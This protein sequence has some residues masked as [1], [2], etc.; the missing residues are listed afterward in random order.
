MNRAYSLEDSSSSI[1]PESV[2]RLLQ[3]NENQIKT[4]MDHFSF[5]LHCLML[6]TGFSDANDDKNIFKLCNKTSNIYRFKY[7][8][9]RDPEERKNFVLMVMS[10]GPVVNVIGNCLGSTGGTFRISGIQISDYIVNCKNP[11]LAARFTNLRALNQS[12]KNLIALP[13][14]NCASSSLELESGSESLLV[15]PEEVLRIIVGKIACAKSIVRLGRSCRLLNSLTEEENVWKQLFWR[16][17]AST[18]TTLS[19]TEKTGVKID[20]KL[21]FREKAQ[22]LTA[23]HLLWRA[24]AQRRILLTAWQLFICF[25]KLLLW[26]VSTWK[27]D[28]FIRP[29]RSW[30]VNE[31]SFD[32]RILLEHL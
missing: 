23:W 5:A 6:E 17:F 10:V 8:L 2:N 11:N 22:I 21:K 27:R 14:I 13:L 24:I 19:E 29:I 31:P 18:Y 32:W 12:F 7:S 28:L 3:A 30:T 1:L 9:Q 26:F 25:Q 16:K 20:W 4:S 15:V